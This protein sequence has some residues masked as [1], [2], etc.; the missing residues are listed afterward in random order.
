[1]FFIILDKIVYYFQ[2]WM[3]ILSQKMKEID[4]KLMYRCD[5]VGM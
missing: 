3:R 2:L 4:Q 1:V 5:N